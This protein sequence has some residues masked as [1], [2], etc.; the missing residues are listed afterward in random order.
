MIPV[1]IDTFIVL[2][3]VYGKFIV[4]RKN[5]FQAEALVKKGL[6]HI[7]S[8]LENLSVIC[9]TFGNEGIIID[10]GTNIGFVSIP[11]AQKLK[12]TNIKII[13]FEPQKQLYHAIHGTLALNNLTNCWIHNQGLG[14]EKGMALVPHVD[15]NFDYD[16]GTV[17]ITHSEQHQEHQYMRWYNVD[18][19]TIDSLDLPRLDLIKLDIEGHELQAIQ[20]AQNSIAQ[21]RPWL[22]VEYFVVGADAVKQTMSQHS[23]YAFFLVDQQNMICAPREKLQF[24]QTQDLTEI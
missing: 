14:S 3:S 11:L 9:D 13:G 1:M 21:F 10:G 6:T 17:S 23:D 15:Y 8:E 7:E 12:N 19:V 24:V 20:G 4:P 2:D 16:F 5:R 18:V 22:W